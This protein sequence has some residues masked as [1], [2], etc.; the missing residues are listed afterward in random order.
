MKILALRGQ[1]LASLQDTFA[2]DFAHSILGDAGLFAIT[3]KTG[4]GKSTLLDAICLALFDRMPRLQASKKNDAEIVGTKANDVRSILSRGQ[5]EGFAEVDFIANDGTKWRAHWQVRRARNRAD[6]RLQNVE[7]WLENIET[8]QRFAGK[9]QE[10]Q[11]K[12]ETLIGLNYEQF[13]RAVIL[14]QGEF[15]AFLKASAD[16]RATLLERMTG[17]EIYG[18]ISAAAYQ[19]AQQEKVK[20]AELIKQCD[21]VELLT[22]EQLEVIKKNLVE[23]KSLRDKNQKLIAQSTEYKAL[24]SHQ[25]ELQQGIETLQVALVNAENSEKQAEPLREKLTHIEAAQDAKLV[26]TQR[27]QQQKT[28]LSLVAQQTEQQLIIEQATTNKSQAQGRVD[29]IMT[30][31][32]E[33]DSSWL[34]IKPKLEQGI[35]L[36]QQAEQVQKLGEE[37]KQQGNALQNKIEEYKK[38][39]HALEQSKQLSKKCL[40]ESQRYLVNNQMFAPIVEQFSAFKDNLQQYN[41]IDQ[42]QRQLQNQTKQLNQQQP[43][44]ERS[45]FDSQ[46]KSS[47]LQ[48]EITDVNQQLAELNQTVLLQQQS[49]LQ[50]QIQQWNQQEKQWQQVLQIGERWLTTTEHIEELNLEL[51]K[52]SSQLAETHQ[53]VE[54]KKPL[55][56]KLTI[57]LEEAKLT[58]TKLFANAKVEQYRYLLEEDQ[59]C[60]LCGSLTHPVSDQ[61]QLIS[62]LL[63]Q[64]QQRVTDLEQQLQQ[65]GQQQQTL[66]L[67]IQQLIAQQYS[68]QKRLTSLKLSNKELILSLIDVISKVNPDAEL[69]NDVTI[70]EYQS[71]KI[72]QQ[73][74][75]WKASLT[76]ILQQLTQG[77]QG[78]QQVQQQLQ[79]GRELQNRWQQLTQA[80]QKLTANLNQQQQALLTNQSELKRL[81]EQQQGYLEQ[82]SHRQQLISQLIPEQKSSEQEITEQEGTE[83]KRQQHWIEQLRQLGYES[84]IAQY[85]QQ[86]TSY[87]QRLSNE[88]NTLEQLNQ[89]Q[90]KI[91]ELTTHLTLLAEDQAKQLQKHQTLQSEWQQLKQQRIAL[92]GE[93]DPQ[94]QSDQWAAKLTQLRTEQQTADK[95]LQQQSETLSAELAKTTALAKQHQQSVEQESLYQQQWQQWLQGLAIN[96]V[97]LTARLQYSSQWIEEQRK[98]LQDLTQQRLNV[99][100]KLAEREQLLNDY[101]P[102]LL[103]A[104]QWLI[105]HHLTTDKIPD[106]Q[107]TWQHQ[108][109][110]LDEQNIT[111]RQQLD[112]AEQAIAQSQSLVAEVNKQQQQSETWL[113]LSDLIGSASGNKFRNI[114]QGLTLRQLTLIANEH[115]TQLAPRYGLQ[116]VENSPLSLQVIDYDMGDE[117]R[118]VESLSGGESFLVSLSLA[119]ALASLATDTKQLGSL[120]I[121]EGFG[122]LDPDSLEMAIS[123]LDTL[124][125]EGRQIGVISHVTTLVERIGTQVAIEAQGGGRSRVVIKSS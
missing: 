124:Q 52:N 55:T 1:N 28:T 68:L 2:I 45:I 35:L 5:S 81:A 119:L 19:R 74:I 80:E 29:K 3:G 33:T 12:L 39:L 66:E 63:Q 107:Q 10:V 102:K 51:A 111:L 88:V 89:L 98:T 82:L 26:Q 71:S 24:F 56:A 101:Q 6:G 16:E 49:Q 23:L 108:Q 118:S 20:L 79:Q 30:N 94:Q 69:T 77:Q 72:E 42:Q 25:V 59:P 99:L 116:P 61:E 110:I 64:Q 46:Q 58:Q 21:G 11:S 105:E 75:D 8:E 14:P 41:Q 123:C 115:L 67:T 78:L 125:A 87:Q 13:R 97:Q 103:V 18:R 100:A 114:A 7:H 57:Q 43:E 44:L 54:E 40:A 9:K 22:P 106:Q 112:N 84:M 37:S 70:I 27:D 122:T 73:L 121:D 47:Q 48:T 91:A 104:N 113:Q 93:D 15:A 53:Q 17:G 32:V 120:F 92:V 38:Q 117:Y 95:Q 4:S 62:D 86:V 36:Q 76:D 34:Q 96:D 109:Q 31:L 50:Q 60:P 83:Q 90:L 85:Q 65:E